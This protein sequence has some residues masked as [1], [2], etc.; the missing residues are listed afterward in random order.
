MLHVY[1]FIKRFQKIKI[2]FLNFLNMSYRS[3]TLFLNGN[4]ILDDM[5]LYLLCFICFQVS[6]IVC[7][8][9]CR[10]H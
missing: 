6:V 9:Y 5:D 8:Q 1:V 10:S 3:W 7:K 2:F 4:V